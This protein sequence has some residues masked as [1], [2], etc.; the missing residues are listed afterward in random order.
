MKKRL[1]SLLLAFSMVLTFLPIGAVSAFADDGVDPT[2]GTMIPNDTGKVYEI[3]EDGGTYQ[4]Q[5]SYDAPIVIYAKNI[6]LN[7]TGDVTYIGMPGK[8]Y[9]SS[10]SNKQYD[11]GNSNNFLL[12]VRQDASVVIHN[13]GDHTIS[14]TDYYRA[15]IVENSNSDVTVYGGTF[16][17][18]NKE[19]VF[20]YG[21]HYELH[22]VN[23]TCTR[24][25]PLNSHNGNITIYGGTIKAGPRWEGYP[26][27]YNRYGGTMILNDV[28][29]ISENGTGLYNE[30]GNVTI[31]GGNYT[32]GYEGAADDDEAGA[33]YNFIKG[34]MTINGGTFTGVKGCNAIVNER[35]LYFNDGTASSD[36]GTALLTRID[37]DRKEFDVTTEITKGT[38][39][40]STYG[41]RLMGDSGGFKTALKLG[42]A[43]FSGNDT[44][45]DLA[46]DKQITIEDTFTDTAKVKCANAVSGRQITTGDDDDYQKNLKLT[47]LDD[48]DNGR[49]YLIGWKQENGQECRYLTKGYTVTTTDATATL[50]GETEELTT[51]VA[52]G[53]KVTV[54]AKD[55]PGYRFTGWEVTA[56]GEKQNA[57][58]FLNYPET[59]DKSSADFVMPDGDVTIKAL[60][61]KLKPVNID[62][63][64]SVANGE[65]TAING[66]PVPGVGE[67]AS[68]DIATAKEGQIVTVTADERL[69][70]QLF[71]GWVVE[72]IDLKD[73][74]QDGLKLT[75]TMPNNDV[76]LAANY[77]EAGF[78][79]EQPV[80]TDDGSDDIQGALSAVVVGAAAGA[81]IY[82]TGTG[83]Y[84]VLNMPGIPM[85]SN[86]IE[87]AELIWE[88]AGK[89][90]PES[91][92]FYSDISED[93]TDWQKAARWAVEQDLMQDDADNNKFNPYF[94]VS[95]LR[96][97]LTWNAAK[98]KGL[99]DKTEE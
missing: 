37:A 95:K 64:I 27:I 46:A 71:V 2:K 4:M 57:D 73:A 38:F 62:Y 87:L 94:P 77:E 45:I 3:T 80:V 51:P 9:E 36:G 96:T 84:R 90:E 67:K 41:L 43:E 5:G 35:T 32:A 99:F 6:T 83:I 65:V 79:P 30:N 28:T 40:N 61:E 76:T 22:D 42:N 88:H 55:K 26:T 81:I 74:K 63:I 39:Q 48:A 16:Y 93:D 18:T 56:G 68:P 98:E 97:C 52:A 89:P 1:I 13:E 85:P 82:E 72:G 53:T 29:V 69:D 10:T 23:I 59:G 11:I 25:I 21:G 58:S 70:S 12:Q 49:K 44:D 7:I 20:S 34:T 75:F 47:S 31:N 92:E 17:S 54:T 33:V 14:G 66:T 60:F 50:E 91:T 24:K 19:T 86:R 78:D 8:K 15:I